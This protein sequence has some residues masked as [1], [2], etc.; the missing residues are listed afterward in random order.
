MTYFRSPQ[1]VQ[2]LSLE[3]PTGNS[4]AREGVETLGSGMRPE[5]PTYKGAVPLELTEVFEISAPALTG[6]G[7]RLPLLRG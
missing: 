5:G 2:K 7:Y 4:R 3:E 1:I 6:P